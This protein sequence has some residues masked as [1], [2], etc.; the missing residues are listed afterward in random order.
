MDKRYQARKTAK[1]I[2]YENNK[3]MEEIVKKLRSKSL[4]KKIENMPH[5]PE[6]RLVDIE[7][8]LVAMSWSWHME[9]LEEEGYRRE[10]SRR[11]YH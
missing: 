7:D 10:R 5:P 2:I 6:V 11:R 3:G 4:R 9:E 8:P 1:D